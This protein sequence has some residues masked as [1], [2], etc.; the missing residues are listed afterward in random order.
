MSF[1]DKI[2]KKICTTQETLLDLRFELETAY[3][4]LQEQPF[5]LAYE[6]PCGQARCP[7]FAVTYTTRLTFIELIFRYYLRLS[8]M[9]VCGSQLQDKIIEDA[10]ASKINRE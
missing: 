6:P 3:E 5:S 4:R 1:R 7:D 9:L 2:R 10:L 8:E